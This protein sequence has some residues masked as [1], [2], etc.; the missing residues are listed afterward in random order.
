MFQKEESV[1]APH[2]NTWVHLDYIDTPHIPRKPIIIIITIIIITSL[3][4]N[5]SKV[6]HTTPPKKGEPLFFA[7]QERINLR[8][9]ILLV[10]VGYCRRRH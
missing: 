2:F 3:L 9:D 8:R 4:F 10:F 7:R 1:E 6:L 5:C